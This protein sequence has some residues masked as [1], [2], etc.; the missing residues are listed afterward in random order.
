MYSNFL[1]EKTML[2]KYFSNHSCRVQRWEFLVS[3]AWRIKPSFEMTNYLL[4]PTKIWAKVGSSSVLGNYSPGS[5]LTRSRSSLPRIRSPPPRH[6]A[7]SGEPSS[8]TSFYTRRNPVRVEAGGVVVAAAA[9][10]AADLQLRLVPI[11]PWPQERFTALCLTS[12]YNNK[13]LYV[14]LFCFFHSLVFL[15][16]CR[17]AKINVGR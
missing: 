3:I 8:G 1:K 5:L 13:L 17:Y 2:T 11:S 4:Q 6:R 16:A 14:F 9:A 15:F 7:R 10:A 12:A